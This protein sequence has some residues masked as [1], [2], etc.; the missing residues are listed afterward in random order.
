M[1]TVVG[2]RSAVAF[3]AIGV[4][5]D[6]G[7]QVHQGARRLALLLMALQ[8]A[9]VVWL[10][11]RP[12]SAAWMTDTNLTPF[13]TV[14]SELSVGTAHAYL[15]LARG[16]LLPAPLG[17]LLPLAG[18]RLDAPALPS[19]LR[20]VFASLLLAT[21]IELFQSTLTSHLLDV[22]DVLLA[23]IGVALTHLLLVPASRAALRRRGR[24]RATVAVR[25]TGFGIAPAVPAAAPSPR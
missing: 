7:H 15:E 22:D 6:E 12:I 14:R 4:D 5:P 17:L 11:F 21:G 2:Q 8:L 16:L 19:F 23:G 13:A 20:T 18:G 1:G 24:N 3:P 9:A 25:A 10:A